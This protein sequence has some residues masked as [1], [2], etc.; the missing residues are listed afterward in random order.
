MGASP[1]VFAEVGVDGGGPRKPFQLFLVLLLLDLE[2]DLARLLRLQK[3][4]LQVLV[5][6]ERL[7]N[8]TL[9]GLLGGVL[10]FK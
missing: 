10:V 7:A 9:N 6:D 5:L 1:V 4:V 2:F 3:P 8:L